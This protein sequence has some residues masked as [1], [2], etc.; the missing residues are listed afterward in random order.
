[1]KIVD[2][3]V[4]LDRDHISLVPNHPPYELTEFFSHP[5]DHR[6]STY[7]KMSTH[8]G[9]HI[10]A[11]YHFVPNG[12]TVEDLPL[13]KLIGKAVLVDLTSE[14]SSGA[15]FTVPMIREAIGGREI[16]GKIVVLHSG[17][18]KKHWGTP[19]MYSSG[20]FL[21][22]ESADWLVNENINALGLDFTMDNPDQGDLTVEKRFP[23][24]RTF[25][26]HDVPHIENLCNLHLIDSGEF[27][28]VALP[29]KL[30]KGDGAP[31]RAIGILD[32]SENG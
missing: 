24:H 30:G 7:L 31:A 28:L 18:L 21:T 27:F 2:L 23:I 8:T 13:E 22:Q 25:L 32:Y 20:P 9:T 14:A 11:P 15:G 19:E 12:G 6:V 10:D 4:V 1:M 29:L 26:G 3:S 16:A 5:T 17:W